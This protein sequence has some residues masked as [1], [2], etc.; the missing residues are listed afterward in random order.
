MSLFGRESA[1]GSSK[2]RSE[3][4]ERAKAAEIV[5]DPRG[6]DSAKLH[7]DTQPGLTLGNIVSDFSASS[8]QGIFQWHERIEGFWALLVSQPSDFAPVCTTEL[9]ALAKLTPDFDKR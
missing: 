8:T 3:E 6:A 4:S 1:H 2:A 5:M 7:P 9:A